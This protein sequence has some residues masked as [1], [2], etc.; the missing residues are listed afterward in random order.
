MLEERLE[1]E[2]ERCRRVSLVERRGDFK[3]RESEGQLQRENASSLRKKRVSPLARRP[4]DERGSS[5][6]GSC[7]R[8]KAF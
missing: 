5:L 7:A 6:K 4:L 8:G 3:R 1:E 2:R